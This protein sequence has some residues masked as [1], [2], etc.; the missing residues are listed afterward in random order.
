MKKRVTTIV[1]FLLTICQPVFSHDWPMWRY[2][3]NR[4]ASTPEQLAGQLY[5]QWQVNYSP[6]N[7]VW[8]DPLNRNLMH[9]DRLFEPVVA[10]NKLFLGFNDQD[11]VVALDLDSGEEL[12]HFYADGPVRLPLAINKNKVYFTGDDGNI[13]CLD[14]ESGELVW[15][16]LL[17]PADNKLLGNKRL[18]SMWPARGG[19]VI[20][21]DIVYTAA[22]IFPLMGTFIYALDAATGNIIWDNEGTG[23]K[24]IKQPHNSPAFAYVAPQGAF[25]V[26]G[27]NLLV[28]GGRSV[29]AAFDLKTGDEVYYHLAANQKNGGAF[30]CAN[31]KVFFNHLRKRQTCMFDSKT[32]E[33][34]IVIAGEY[35]VID[36]DNIYFSGKKIRASYLTD[37]LTLD[38]LWSIDVPAKNDLIKAGDCLYAADSTGVYALKLSGKNKPEVIWHFQSDKNIERLIAAN[39]KLVAVTSDGSIMVFGDKPV[40]TVAD[41]SKYKCDKPLTVTSDIIEETCIKDGYCLVL[42]GD[43]IQVLKDLVYGSSLRIVVY[44]KNQQRINWLREYFDN[45]GVTADRL[46]F[47]HFGDKFPELPKYFSSLTVINDFAYLNKGREEWLEKVYESSRPYGGKII[48]QGKRR[49]RKQLMQAFDKLQLPG[50]EIYAGKDY[51][52]VTRTGALE[53]ASPWTHNY[54][55]IANT[56]KSDDKLV[57]APLGILWFGGNSNLDVLPRHGHGP[58]EQVIDGRLIIQGINSVSARDVYTGQVLWKRE[59]DELKDDNWL[60]YFDETYDEENPLIPKYN[61]VHLPG[62]NARGTNYIATKEY[63]YLILGDKC[64]VMDINTGETVKVFTPDNEVEGKLGYI[65]VYNDLLILGKGFADFPGMENDSMRIK[66]HRFTNYNLTASKKII[67]LD[68]FSG[69]KM[70][71]ISSNHGFIHNSIIAGDGKIFC[72]DK[73]PQYIETKMK[74]RGL[75]LPKDSRLLYLDAQ[76]GEITKEET[77][78]VFGTWLGYSDEYKL[79]LQATRPSR[80]MLHGEVGERMITYDLRTNKKI[81]DREMKYA[82]PPIIHN[83]KIYTNGEGFYL[84]TGDPIKEK[85]PVTGEDLKWSFKREYGCGIV[86]ASEHLLTFRS[87]SAGFVNLDEFEGTGSLGGWKASCSTNLIP[88]DGVLNSPDY[89]RTC[90]CAYQNQTSLALINMPWMTYWTNSNYQWDGKP[91]RQLGLN[92]NAP[93]DRSADDNV[94]WFEF[95]EVAG[96]PS[97]IPIKIDTSGYRLIRKEPISIS[98]GQTPWVSASAIAGIRSVEITLSNDEF[99]TESSYTVKLYFAELEDIKPGERSFDIKIQGEKVCENFD[100]VKKAGTL[101]KEVVVSYECIKAGKTMKIDLVPETGNTLISGIEL[102]QEQM[103]EK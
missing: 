76:T 85:D 92:L 102:S 43:D 88:A 61:Q 48:V 37:S 18:I 30:T 103:A 87:A 51:S 96:N 90:Q 9:Y 7:P 11:K 65:G 31:D 35:P 46:S 71:D 82:N 6:R 15:K 67:V 27:D 56:V 40:E 3:Y 47:Q 89:T 38:T 62:S 33:R 13:Y 93:G 72:L 34:L 60:V 41:L 29:P 4:S 28:A 84:L 80:D 20:K 75:D 83:D 79:L 66:N 64:N 69:E 81:W 53:G 44:E 45:E 55:D 8:D 74:R 26:S 32:G 91:I 50:A 73:L 23:S 22:S 49:K 17:A 70:W 59:F 12:W 54:G 95:P 2:G 36:G 94:L 58:G 25:T 68:R 5:L 16:R 39:Q 14:S 86:A 100:I 42:G 1:L 99:A 57:K 77:N 101:N 78:D 19:V 98:S 97:G 10:G 21:D 24:Y 63:V 52:L